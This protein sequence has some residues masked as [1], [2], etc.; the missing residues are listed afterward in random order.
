MDNDQK[1]LNNYFE[2][3]KVTDVN[4]ARL[5]KMH[6]NQIICR[7]GCAS[8]CVNL[9]LFPVEFEAI[10][11]EISREGFDISKVI[12]DEDAAC[13]FLKDDLC[14]IYKYRPIICRTHGLPIAFLNDDDPEEIF[15]EVSFC[16]LNFN[17]F[18]DDEGLIFNDD[19]TLDIDELNS[20]FFRIN[21]EFCKE[22]EKRIP[23]KDLLLT[24]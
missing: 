14:Q 2:L 11:A 4:C 9:S 6:K 8:C 15:K 12:F 10:K 24:S 22:S 7:K 3:R 18:E 23:L 20:A 19:N 13:G 16:D 5:E 21:Y 17:N 1:A